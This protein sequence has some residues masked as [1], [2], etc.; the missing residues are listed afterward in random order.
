MSD[1]DSDAEVRAGR[2][3]DEIKAMLGE[4]YVEDEVRLCQIHSAHSRWH[5]RSLLD[6]LGLGNAESSTA[7]EP[8]EDVQQHT[9]QGEAS[10]EEDE[11][12]F[13]EEASA[14]DDEEHGYNFDFDN[15]DEDMTEGS[16]PASG[17][18]PANFAWSQSTGT[19]H[20]CSCHDDVPTGDHEARRPAEQTSMEK[21]LS[22]KRFQV[23]RL[24]E[25]CASRNEDLEELAGIPAAAKV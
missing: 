2:L 15:I 6:G 16:R 1:S 21:W 14:G 8:D 23:Q 22:A 4:E 12:Q 5:K 17:S 13:E 10:E 3:I 18:C 24:R 25:A 9:E 20:L 19:N 11:A 7:Q